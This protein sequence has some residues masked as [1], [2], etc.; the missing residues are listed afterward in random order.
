MKLQLLKCT[1][2]ISTGK[3][4][5]SFRKTGSPKSLMCHS[6]NLS[7]FILAILILVFTFFIGQSHAQGTWTP[8]AALAPHNNAGVSLLLSDGSVIAVG[9][10]PGYYAGNNWDRLTPDSLGSYVNGTW[11]NITPM[12]DTRLY[13]S[14][15]M[16]M[17]GRIYVAGGEY[18]SGSYYAETYDPVTD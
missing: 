6:G 7:Q 10:D 4:R 11:S 12:N 17:D 14:S 2:V 16:L 8:V 9:A 13:Y 5:N 18:G 3:D 1:D 15:Q